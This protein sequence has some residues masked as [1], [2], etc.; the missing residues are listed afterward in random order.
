M[1]VR[2]YSKNVEVPRTGI[3]PMVQQ[4]QAAAVTMPDAYPTGQQENSLKNWTF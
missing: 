1:W 4:Q 2:L 3:K